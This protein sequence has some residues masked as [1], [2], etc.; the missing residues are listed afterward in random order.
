ML[1][2]LTEDERVLHAHNIAPGPPK[3][4]QHAGE[5]VDRLH[6]PPSDGRHLDYLPLHQLNPIVLAEDASV[7]HLAELLDGEA[8][9]G[10]LRF[11]HL[12][13]HLPSK[14]RLSEYITMLTYN[15]PIRC[16]SDGEPYVFYASRNQRPQRHG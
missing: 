1:A 12:L 9:L 10:D 11:Q 4:S 2:V 5:G 16:A 7:A 6:V 15:C 13:D 14:L 8:V 3:V